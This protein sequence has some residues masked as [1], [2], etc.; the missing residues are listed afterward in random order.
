[1]C[2]QHYIF[3]YKWEV[4]THKRSVKNALHA[5][6]FCSIIVSVKEN[7]VVFVNSSKPKNVAML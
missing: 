7:S 3:L 6:Q 5:Y 2:T 1:M 4:Y